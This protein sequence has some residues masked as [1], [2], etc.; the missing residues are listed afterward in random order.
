[1]NELQTVLK[2]LTEE[3]WED[4]TTGHDL[5][6]AK[7]YTDMGFPDEFVKRFIMEIE[8]DLSSPKTTIYDKDMNVLEK[9]IGIYNLDFLRGLERAVGVKAEGSLGRG[10][11]ARN[12]ITALQKKL[13]V[14]LT[15]DY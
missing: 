5:F 9:V 11:E 6:K 7:F 1:M 14:P 12:I 8:S 4:L 15:C 2:G 13:E 3:Q 10:R